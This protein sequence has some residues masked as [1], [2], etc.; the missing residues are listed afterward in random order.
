[1]PDL[2]ICLN[3]PFI[4]EKLK[5]FNITVE[6]YL[7]HLEGKGFDENLAKINYHDVTIDFKTFYN[8]SYVIYTNGS[9]KRVKEIDIH[10]SF[11]GF[12]H[13]FLLKCVQ[14]KPKISERN[15]MKYLSLAFNMDFL[16]YW[17]KDMYSNVIAKPYHS[18]QFL[19][20]D[21]LKFLNVE[22]NETHGFSVGFLITKVEI[23]RKRNKGKYH[24]LANSTD[25]DKSVFHDQVQKISCLAP[26]HRPYRN[27]STCNTKKELKQWFN[28]AGKVQNSYRDR[29]PCQTMPR[30]DSDILDIKGAYGFI[31]IFIGFPNE[32]KIITQSRAIDV[33]ALIGNIG[34]Y[35]GLFL[36]NS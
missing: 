23:L 8:E 25:W 12:W 4:D 7:Y 35:I 9:T 31:Q 19:L 18:H 2:S 5:S 28:W 14:F 10:S 11:N 13:G 20:Q 24:C 36:G 26:Y 32:V 1:M 17:T 6:T 29:L 16:Q 34:G 30:I 22:R 3:D 33:D 21:T 27:F 15:N